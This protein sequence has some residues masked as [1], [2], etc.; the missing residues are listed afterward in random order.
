M[1][2]YISALFLVVGAIGLTGCNSTSPADSV[3]AAPVA[4]TTTPRVEYTPKAE[5]GIP[6][7]QNPDAAAFS[8]LV[9]SKAGAFVARKDP[10]ALN[11]EEAAFD[12]DQSS[13]RLLQSGG[14]YSMD[15]VAPEPK[16]DE[17]P[18]NDPQPYRRLAGVVVGDSVLALVV[19]EDGRTEVIRPGQQ[20]PNSEWKVVAIDEESAVLRRAGNRLPRQIIVRLESPPAGFAPA[21][22]NAGGFPPAGAPGIPGGPGGRRG[23]PPGGQLGGGDK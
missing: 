13:E 4:E 10:F 8:K 18:V 9:E 12:R 7:A 2:N 20:I 19:M 16:I 14:G 22:P 11:P 3:P 17:T 15:Y 1:K 23:G 21:S 6:V 5:A